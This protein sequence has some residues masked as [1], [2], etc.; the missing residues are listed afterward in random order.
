MTHTRCPE[1]RGPARQPCG[2]CPYRRDVASGIWAASEYAKLTAYDAD[3][4]VQPPNLFL[5][6][7]TAPDDHKARLCAG[8]VGCHGP[9]LLALRLAAATGQ[10][11]T[12]EVRAAFD[13]T[14]TVPLFE[15][16]TA[17]ATH[18]TRDIPTPGPRAQQAI[19]K[20][21]AKRPDTTRPGR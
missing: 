8:W 17:A 20:I 6:H 3:T 7:Q 13:Y 14:T 10:L 15:S 12:T 5:C 11:T 21:A 16:G 18:G 4:P 19:T 2:S 1:V 9:D